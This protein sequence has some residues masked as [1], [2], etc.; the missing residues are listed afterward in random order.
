M[1]IILDVI[2]DTED[3]KKKMKFLKNY[4]Y[5]YFNNLVKFFRV[6]YLIESLRHLYSFSNSKFERNS[7]LKL[8]FFDLIFLS[9]Y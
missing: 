1:F 4:I 9:P 2:Q 3:Y 6:E 5:K 7:T 8:L